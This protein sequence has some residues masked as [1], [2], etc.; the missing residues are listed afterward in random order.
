MAQGSKIENL[1]QGHPGI[2]P[3]QRSS[4]NERANE[5]GR[6]RQPRAVSVLACAEKARK[7]QNKQDSGAF[8]CYADDTESRIDAA[9]AALAA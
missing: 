9:R 8:A 4:S 2:G 3:R 7:I 6:A 5:F 1:H